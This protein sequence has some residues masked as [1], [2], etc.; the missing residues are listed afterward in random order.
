MAGNKKKKKKNGGRALK[1]IIFLFLILVVL[2]VVLAFLTPTESE[3]E[4]GYNPTYIADL[5]VPAGGKGEVIE[6]TGYTLSYNEKYEVPEWVA[7]E[8]TREE[9][10]TQSVER[11][12]NFREDKAVTTGSATL[13]DYK[14]SGYDRGHMAPAADFRWSFDAMNDTFY[15]SNMCPQTHAFNAG[16]WSD[17]EEAVRSIAYEDECIYVVT[18]PVLTDGPYE[19]IGEN[20]VAVPKY[21]YKVIL[22]Y[23]A[24]TIKAIGFIMPHENSKEPLS[25]FAVTVDEVEDITGLDFFP[26]LPD[27]E[28]EKLESSLDTTL[29]ALKNFDYSLIEKANEEG[30]VYVENTNSNNE[31]RNSIL[32]IFMEVFYRFKREVFYALGIE[33]E[34]RAIGLL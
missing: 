31:L 18:G 10:V 19:T 20:K 8:L 33:K 14:K 15:L 29:W 7:Y 34:A 21:F 3:M 4:D 27:D 2:F 30:R 23:T 16:I 5:E 22:D 28:E 11:K 26:L 32:D 6:H 25:Y 9:V 13:N 12:D 24:P 17:L 1:R